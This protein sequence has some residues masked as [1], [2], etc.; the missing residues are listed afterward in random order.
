M[1]RDA[2]GWLERRARKQMPAKPLRAVDH[3]KI[4]DRLEELN[5]Q[6]VSVPFTRRYTSHTYAP[7]LGYDP[8]GGRL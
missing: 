7:N 1:P 2:G 5:A 4:M 8:N 6:S 3:K